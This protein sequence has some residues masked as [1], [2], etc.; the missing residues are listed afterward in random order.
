MSKMYVE[1]KH[2][3]IIAPTVMTCTNTVMALTNLSSVEWSAKEIIYHCGS[4]KRTGKVLKVLITPQKAE[5]TR[6]RALS[7][8]G[9]K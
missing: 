7:T 8:I 2:Y 1:T 5:T 9:P 3:L 6:V 4:S